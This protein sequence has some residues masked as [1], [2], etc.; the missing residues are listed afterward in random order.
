MTAHSQGLPAAVYGEMLRLVHESGSALR[1]GDLAPQSAWVR[2]VHSDQ[3]HLLVAAAL[4]GALAALRAE[5][6]TARDV[7]EWLSSRAAVTERLE[8]I[9]GWLLDALSLRQRRQS[10][11]MMVT[12]TLAARGWIADPL[13]IT[14]LIVSVFVVASDVRRSVADREASGD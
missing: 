12:D 8:V 10:E 11:L 4:S 9:S 6:I 13:T 14:S 7:K 5:Q 1:L 2:S 3:G